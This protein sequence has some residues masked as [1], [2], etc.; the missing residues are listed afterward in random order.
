MVGV[1]KI[2][3]YIIH[4]CE[5]V[6]NSCALHRFPEWKSGK[7]ITI[8]PDVTTRELMTFFLQNDISFES[9]FLLA[10]VTYGEIF[11]GGYIPFGSYSTP[12][13]QMRV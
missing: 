6:C 7:T 11:S 8:S 9:D 12:L 5:C 2:V 3:S 4:Y 1:H 10:T 13:L